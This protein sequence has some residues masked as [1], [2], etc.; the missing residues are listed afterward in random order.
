M[1]INEYQNQ[2]K[3]FKLYPVEIG[4]F[5]NCICLQSAIGQLS[6]KISD[7][8]IDPNLK[9]DEDYAL[10]IGISLGDI[11]GYAA[12]LADDVGMSLE[13]ICAI[14]LRKLNLARQKAEKQQNK[15]VTRY[16]QN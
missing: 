6:E 1:E 15:Q 5:Y 9:I 7:L 3:N 11:I 8:I 13:E 10:K 2:T 12:N 4:P 14:N 16:E